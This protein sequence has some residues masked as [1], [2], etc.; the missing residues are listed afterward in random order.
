MSFFI[1]CP[2]FPRGISAASDVCLASLSSEPQHAQHCLCSSASPQMLDL[3]DR[4]FCDSRF[5]VPYIPLA[6]EGCYGCVCRVS[7]YLLGQHSEKALRASCWRGRK[8]NRA[9][10]EVWAG[11]SGD[12]RDLQGWKLIPAKLLD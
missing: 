2:I 6:R 10:A 4:Y 3:F 8:G 11:M 9:R 7:P 12:L 5:P 1:L